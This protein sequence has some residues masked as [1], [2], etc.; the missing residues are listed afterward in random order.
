MHR[1]FVALRPPPSIG[2]ACLSAME[3]GPPGWA[4]QSEEQLHLTLRYIG[5]VDRPVAEDV[6]GQDRG[7]EQV[8]LEVALLAGD[9]GG[10]IGGAEGFVDLVRFFLLAAP[11]VEEAARAQGF[12]QLRGVRVGTVGAKAERGIA[13]TGGGGVGE[14]EVVAL[15][16][17][18]LRCGGMPGV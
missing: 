4:W 3:D 1:L 11:G 6:A 7:G 17:G 16:H 9:G 8:D 13:A 2:Q 15:R 5:E 12:L 18:C 10:G 14:G